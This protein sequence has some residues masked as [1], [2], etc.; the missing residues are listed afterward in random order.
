MSIENPPVFP[1]KG[2]PPQQVVGDSGSFFLPPT[3]DHPGM[4]LRDYFAGQALVGLLASSTFT[5]GGD[6][7]EEFIANKADNIAD[8]MLTARQ[9]GTPDE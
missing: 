3:A 5:N 1:R 4:T 2:V 7:F 9:K 8:A 6:G